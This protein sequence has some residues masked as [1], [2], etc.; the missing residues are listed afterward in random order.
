MRRILLTAG[1][2]VLGTAAAMAQT[3]P[4]VPNASGSQVT[5]P[6]SY[7]NT[8]SP[9]MPMAAPGQAVTGNVPCAPVPNASGSQTTNPC[10]YGSTASSPAYQGAPAATGSIGGPAVAPAP[11]ASGSQVTNPGS[12]GDTK[13]K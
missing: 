13:P 9:G 2:L 8:A 5:N 4:P 3:P 6:G 7:G 12:Y 10:S 1:A 11:N